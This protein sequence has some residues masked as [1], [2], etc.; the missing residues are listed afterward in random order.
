MVS[1]AE[2]V[3]KNL[4]DVSRE[5]EKVFATAAQVVKDEKLRGILERASKRCAIGVR[6]WT[7]RLSIRAGQ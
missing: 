5:G 6:N 4:A 1:N 3:M 2:S 7:R